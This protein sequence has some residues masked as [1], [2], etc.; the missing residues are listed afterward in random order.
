MIKYLGA[1][2]ILHN[3]V[4]G[5]CV[6]GKLDANDYTLRG[7]ALSTQMIIYYM[8]NFTQLIFKVFNENF[9][10]SCMWHMI[11]LIYAAPLS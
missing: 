1:V 10:L 5:E 2:H 7:G 8:I 11:C 3:H 4:K 6:N 9:F